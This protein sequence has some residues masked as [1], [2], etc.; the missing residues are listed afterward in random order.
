MLLGI[1]VTGIL[2]LV[3]LFLITGCAPGSLFSPSK[4]AQG[5]YHV[6]RAGENL[7]R[8]GKAYDV[9]HDELAR[10]NQ[11]RHANQIRAGQRIFIPGATRQLPVEVITP[12]ESARQLPVDPS[13][14]TTSDQKFIW[15]ISGTINS[16]FG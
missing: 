3:L 2:C 1:N 13:L 7:Y 15:P 10:V 6:V 9:S 16:S 8:I 5:I 11:L 4:R 12:G 14:N